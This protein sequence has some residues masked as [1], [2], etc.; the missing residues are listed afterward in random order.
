M[1]GVIFDHYPRSSLYIAHPP[2]PFW[3]AP[4]R[5]LTSLYSPPSGAGIWWLFKPVRS[6]QAGGTHPSGSFLVVSPFI[7][8]LQLKINQ[9]CWN[10]C[11][12]YQIKF[13]QIGDL[14]G[15]KM[16][17]QWW[18]QF[19][20]ETNGHNIGYFIT[21]RGKVVFWQ[22]CIRDGGRYT[23]GGY[24]RGWVSGGVGIP[25]RVIGKRRG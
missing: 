1:G 12:C 15:E 19:I 4:S 2:P 10:H 22:A 20:Q 14:H 21:V 13:W 24:I 17:S 7:E 18:R 8:T 9:N 5:H 11:P 16:T 3:P 6:V 25:R 23:E